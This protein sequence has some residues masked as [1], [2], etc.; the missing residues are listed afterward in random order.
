MDRTNISPKAYSE[1]RQSLLLDIA[2][3][4][5]LRVGFSACSMDHISRVSGVSKSTIYRHYNNKNE[6]LKAVT[7]R[8][9]DDH[10]R[11]V[12]AF[13]LDDDDPVVSLRQFA[14]HIYNIETQPRHREFLRLYIAEAQNLPFLAQLVREFGAGKTLG[15]LSD[16]FRCLIEAGRM[17]HPD[18]DQAALTFYTLARGNLRPLFGNLLDDAEEKRRLHIDIDLF[19]KGCELL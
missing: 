6:L 19:L 4:E 11:Q 9:A 5:F 18:P 15:R 7:L 13:G 12:S 8:L 10:C 2:V 3:E 17:G 14:E 16:Y 1:R